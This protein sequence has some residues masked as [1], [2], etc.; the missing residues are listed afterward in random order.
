[1]NIPAGDLC[2]RQAH[3][4]PLD[5]FGTRGVLYEMGDTVTED[6]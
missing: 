2:M 4:G 5:W 3:K 6:F 1:M